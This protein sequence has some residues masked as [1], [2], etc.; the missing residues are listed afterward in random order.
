[1]KCVI[2]AGGKG[3]R[4]AEESGTRPKPMLEI[5][6]RPILW[7][8]MKLYAAFGVSEFIVCLGYKG[9]IVKEYFANYFLH[10]A[11]VTFDMSGNRVEYHDCRSEPWKVTLVDTGEESMTGGRLLQVE[12]Y[13]NPGEAF[14]MTYGD[15]LANIDIAAEIAFHAQRG[16]KATVACVRPPARF[17][18]VVIEGTQAISFEEKPQAETGLINGGFF[19][20][21]PSV[22]ELIDGAH[23]VW[24]KEPMESLAANGQLAAWIHRGFW[25]PMDTPRDK[26]HL[27]AL[28]DSGTA[29]WKLW[30]G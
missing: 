8:I 14:C 5:G 28:W 15:G 13:L 30:Q 9:Y 12:K 1:M 2:L 10:Q 20:L 7:H 25:Q 17:G 26:Q 11:D 6:G 22:L 27:N 18:R 4:I 19:V 29:P 23:T 3:T 16:C 24:E 21:D